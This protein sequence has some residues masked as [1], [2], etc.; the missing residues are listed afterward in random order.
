MSNMFERFRNKWHQS[1]KGFVTIL[2]SEIAV[3]IDVQAHYA[4]TIQTHNAVSV[5]ASGNSNS[6][7]ID[8][9]GFDKVA[10]TVLN[11]AAT[12]SSVETHWSNDGINAHGAETLIVQS[13]SPNKVGIS[14]IKARYVRVQLKNADTVAHTMSAWVYLKA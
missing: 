7:Y 8:C 4:K 13:T 1:I 5:G 10:F 12:N 6:S 2:A 3:P 9:D 14:D 11:D